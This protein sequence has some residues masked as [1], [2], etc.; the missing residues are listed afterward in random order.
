MY[1]SLRL[2]RQS[3]SRCSCWWTFK[4]LMRWGHLAW[5]GDL[6]LTF[7]QRKRKRCIKRCVS[8]SA[9]RS[10]AVFCQSGK[11]GGGTQDPPPIRANGC[12]LGIQVDKCTHDSFNYHWSSD[13][14]IRVHQHFLQ[15]YFIGI[16]Q[17]LKNKCNVFVSL[18]RI[19]CLKGNC[20]PSENAYFLFSFKYDFG[21]NWSECKINIY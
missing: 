18:I 21:L 11:T 12:S 9:G 3:F 19:D 16:G 5:P 2:L 4:L 17:R 6:G 1:Q 10:A 15:Y 8:K 20:S 7:S 13:D 14:V